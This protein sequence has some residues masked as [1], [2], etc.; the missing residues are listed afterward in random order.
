MRLGDQLE[1]VGTLEV[2]TLEQ[3]RLLE[4]Q[5]KRKKNPRLALYLLENHANKSGL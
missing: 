1:I 3:A 4:R 2:A 5:M